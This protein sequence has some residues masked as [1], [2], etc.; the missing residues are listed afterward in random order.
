MTASRIA[1][2]AALATAAAFGSTVAPAV[3]GNGETGN[4]APS[5]AH[6]QFNIIGVDKGKTADMTGDN[7]RRMFV[8]LGRDGTANTR[9]NLTEGEF[10]VLDANGTDGVAAFQLPNPDPDG[11]GTTAY[12]V[13]VRALGKPGGSATMQSCYDDKTSGDT[14][15]AVDYAGGV[16]PITITRSKGGVGKFENV[17]KDLLYVD[18]CR[19]VDATTGDCTSW[20]QV[21]L[22]NDAN[23]N[24]D[25]DDEAYFWDYD[26]NGLKVAQLRFYEVPTVTPW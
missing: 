4:G 12:S 13:F 21:P 3:A 25:T 1:L 26:N 16:E 20:T 11:D 14:W 7:G 6:Y 24:G 5:G 2:C 8:G 15:C 18:A 17:S 9:I 23:G 19:A 10:D 22:F